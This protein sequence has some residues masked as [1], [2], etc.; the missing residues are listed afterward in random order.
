[1]ID[2]DA[3]AADLNGQVSAYGASAG[4]GSIR[5]WRRFTLRT[6]CFPPC[7]HEPARASDAESTILPRPAP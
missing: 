4:A 3:V 5:L 1:M 6:V 2:G 7:R